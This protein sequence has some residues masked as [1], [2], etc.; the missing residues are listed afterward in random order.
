MKANLPKIAV[1]L[2]AYN[3]VE[4]L[5]EQVSSILKQVNVDVTLFISVDASLDGTEALVDRLKTDE[6]IVALPHGLKFGAAGKNFYRLLLDVDFSNVDFISFA[7]QDDI[8]EQDKLA[9]HAELMRNNNVEGVSSNVT[10]FWPSGKTAVINKSQPQCK[11]DYLFESAG[12]GCT[13]LISPWLA[14]QVKV[15]LKDKTSVAS[16]VTLHDWLVYAVCRAYNKGWIIDS[17]PSVQYRQHE[18]NVVGANVGLKAK[19]ARI[20][21]LRQGWYRKEVLKVVHICN[22]INP[23]DQM[24]KLITL[25]NSGTLFSTFRLLTFVPQARRRLVDRL[26]LAASIVTG[27]F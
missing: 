13:F 4:H 25:L 22:H 20:K 16:Q 12:P 18:L 23:T 17:V 9:R 19:W 3:G 11:F 1:C 27:L 24:N 26:L 5:S 6:R 10:A 8:W 7:D 15:L 21:K 14:A 2:A